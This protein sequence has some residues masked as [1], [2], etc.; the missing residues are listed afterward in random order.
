MVLKNLFRRKTRT[1]LT[2][3]GISVGV[4]AIVTLGT[5]SAGLYTG[6]SSM[7]SGTKADLILSQPDSYDISMSSIGEEIGSELAVMPEV[8][9]ITGMLQ[10]WAQAEGEPFFFVFGHPEDSFVLDRFQVVGGD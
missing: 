7:L 3:V 5:L 10:G 4:A 8:E 6:Y 9:E 2:I 1:L